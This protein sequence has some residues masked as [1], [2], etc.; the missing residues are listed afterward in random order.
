MRILIIIEKYGGFCNRLFQSLHYHAYAIEK[1]MKFF[2]PSILGLLKFDNKFYYFLDRLNNIFLKIVSCTFKV[3]FKKKDICFYFNKNNYIRIVSGW[4]FRKY[5]LTI[6]YRKELNQIYSFNENKLSKRSK[7][8]INFLKGLKKKGKFLVGLHIRKK[9]YKLWNNGK[10]YYDEDSYKYIIKN[11]KEKLI[12]EDKDPFIV[13]VSD[14]KLSSKDYFDYHSEG[15]WKEDQI[16]LQ[17]CDLI[18][19]P[20]STFT[21]WASYIAKKP[22]I[23]IY[24]KEDDNF[25]NS[26][27]C[28]G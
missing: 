25:N 3:F 18:I 24:S 22:L 6:K 7:F 11:L 15:S 14:D 4:H 17:C 13:V 5:K 9:D 2:N 21:M 28:D 19:G 20:P 26:L 12:K 27:I 16:T 1:D 10:Y 8:L 23:K